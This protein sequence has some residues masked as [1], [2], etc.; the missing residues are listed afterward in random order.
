[1]FGSPLLFVSTLPTQGSIHSPIGLG[2]EG[3]GVKHHIRQEDRL[4][5]FIRLSEQPLAT[6]W[7][8][9]AKKLAAAR[10]KCAFILGGDFNALAE[11]FLFGA[12]ES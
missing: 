7:S 5:V 3:V 9:V 8:D 2:G 10:H 1:M 6:P 4:S 11:E 12:S